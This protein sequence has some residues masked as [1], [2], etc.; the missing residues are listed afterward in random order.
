MHAT[1]IS[2]ADAY[3]SCRPVPGRGIVVSVV[4]SVW[5]LVMALTL[6]TV[7]APAAVAQRTT[8]CNPDERIRGVSFDGSPNF[9]VL[10]LATNIVTHEPG[11]VTR[12]FKIGTPPCVDTLE[13][14]R[15]ALR[16]A[17]LHRQAGWFQA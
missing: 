5:H 8:R 15:D 1:L 9:D 14:R 7:V 2:S 6:L 3:T 10:T 13:V 11:F 12:V 4:R 16:I 17:I